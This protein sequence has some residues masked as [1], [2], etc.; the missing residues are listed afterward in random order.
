MMRNL[1]FVTRLNIDS[2]C[3][4]IIDCFVQCL[5]SSVG[6]KERGVLA[7]IE[8]NNGAR[9]IQRLNRVASRFRQVFRIPTFYNRSRQRAR[10]RRQKRAKTSYFIKRLVG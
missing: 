2:L 9:M 8:M 7:E 5:H 3:D 6:C 10:R 4:G 1:N